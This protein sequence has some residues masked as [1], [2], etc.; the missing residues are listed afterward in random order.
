M[1]NLKSIGIGV[2]LIATAFGLPS[3]LS[4]VDIFFSDSV[5]LIMQ[6]GIVVTGLYYIA[7][8]EN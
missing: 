7:G 8:D 4:T 5:Q 6:L 1:S 3:I 2:F